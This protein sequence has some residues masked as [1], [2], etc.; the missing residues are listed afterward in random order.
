MICSPEASWTVCAEPVVHFDLNATLRRLCAAW[1]LPLACPCYDLRH[2]SRRFQQ[3][4]S[5]LSTQRMTRAIALATVWLGVDCMLVYLGY[6]YQVRCLV[7]LAFLA[8]TIRWSPAARPL[9]RSNLTADLRVL[10]RVVLWGGAAELLIA[11][12]FAVWIFGLGNEIKVDGITTHSQVWRHW[13]IGL[14]MAPIVE[15]LLFRGLFQRQLE[16][17]LGRTLAIVISGPVFWVYH[18]ISFGGVTP[19]NH[20]FAGWVLAWSYAKT[21]SLWVAIALHALGNLSVLL[22]H[23]LLIA[24]S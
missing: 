3:G 6:F 1:I 20:M 4:G 23:S 11:A 14:L 24:V 21:G 12:G 10:G 2:G 16:V 7:A 17:G 8:A 13:F 9:S 18:W 15:E 5:P 19:L 22:F